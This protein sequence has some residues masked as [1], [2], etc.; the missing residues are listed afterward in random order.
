MAKTEAEGGPADRVP[1]TEGYSC[2]L[3]A[4]EEGE[5]CG[6]C[7]DPICAKPRQPAG[8]PKPEDPI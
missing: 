4:F 6:D 2:Y 7:V 3:L 8:G 5:V 1:P